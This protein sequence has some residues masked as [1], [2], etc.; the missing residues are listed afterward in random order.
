V[1]A[2]GGHRCRQRG[3]TLVEL[4]VSLTLTIMIVTSLYSGLHLAG[5]AWQ[6]GSSAA[7]RAGEVTL[8]RE[9]LRRQLTQMHAI[10]DPENAGK[11]SVLFAGGPE[12]L[13]FIGS[14]PGHLGGGGL[15]LL[16]LAPSADDPRRLLLEH[17]AFPETL[18]GSPAP[19]SRRVL[20]DD[21]EGV[22]FRYFGAE[23]P[24]DRPRWF[25]AWAIETHLPLA[26][27]V[28]VDPRSPDAETWPPLLVPVMTDGRSK[29]ES[30]LVARLGVAAR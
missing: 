25:E 27:R 15:H 17:R 11:P 30:P 9:W 18:A 3:L 28:A 4:L 5:R 10:M 8:V 20:L 6:Q 26:I 13:S 21:M 23:K 29:R 22:S 24:D 16:T 2:Y 14:L 7:E 19:V 1:G 12:S